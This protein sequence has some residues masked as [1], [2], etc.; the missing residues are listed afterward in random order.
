MCHYTNFERSDRPKILYIVF[1]HTRL[2]FPIKQWN[3]K[4]LACSTVLAITGSIRN[5][6]GGLRGQ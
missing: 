3:L 4:F 1:L 2:Q 5:G 6:N